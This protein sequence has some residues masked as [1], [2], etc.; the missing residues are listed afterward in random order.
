[1]WKEPEKASKR[2]FPPN[3]FGQYILKRERVLKK[4]KDEISTQQQWNDQTQ[5]VYLAG[6]RGSGKTSLEMLLAKDF[7]AKGYEVYFFKSASDIPQGASLA[8]E[9]LLKDKT[10]MFAVLIDEV[11]SNPEAGLFTTLLKGGYPHLVV[12]GSA[13]PRFIS[14]GITAKFESVLRMADLV[15]K[16]EDDDFLGLIEYCAGLK[17]TT[18]ELTQ[19]I[20][21]YLLKQC[22]GH[23]FPTLAFIEHFFTLYDTKEFL[24]SM[25]VFQKHFSGPHFAS[26]PFHKGVRSRCFDELL[27]AETEMMA[28]R[29]LGGREEVGD[30]TTVIRLGW[31]DPDTRDFISPFFVNAFMCG[32]QPRADDVLYLSEKKTCEE[33]TELVII[34]GLSGMEDSDFK[35]WRHESGIKVED[36][37][38]FNWAYRAKVKVPNAF[39]Q[40]QER[41]A[42]GNVDFYLNGLADTAIEVMLDATK[43]ADVN[44]QRQSQDIDGHCDRFRSDKYDWKRYVLLNFNMRNCKIVLPRD[45][46]VHDKV[47]TFI[48]ENNTLYRGDKSIRSPAVPKLPGGSRPMDDQTRRYSTVLRAKCPNGRP[49]PLVMLKHFIARIKGL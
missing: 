17:A 16:S 42:S 8:F 36:G 49:V 43:T 21:I 24:V 34:E 3:Q 14:T 32:V 22:G 23:T 29:V 30:I 39:L 47:Y 20:C 45:V 15:L 46:S 31:W 13:V 11:A 35:C 1:M 33:N 44:S 27:N 5:S 38:S 12:I 28:F 7:K 9:A 48:R 4:V 40:F 26:S 2:L 37:V 18:P 41:G 6:C 10:K 19:L 25:E